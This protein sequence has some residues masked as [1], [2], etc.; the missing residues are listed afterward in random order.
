M[1]LGLSGPCGRV[2]FGSPTCRGPG[3]KTPGRG[4]GILVHLFGGLFWF[5]PRSRP[6]GRSESG[7]FPSVLGG[8]SFLLVTQPGKSVSSLTGPCLEESAIWSSA[9]SLCGLGGVILPAFGGRGSGV[10]GASSAPG[11][12]WAS[13]AG[14][15]GALPQAPSRTAPGGGAV[16]REAGTWRELS[17]VAPCGFSILPW[18]TNLAWSFKILEVDVVFFSKA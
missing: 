13:G 7:L 15:P 11:P 12:V 16:A 9:S 8:S 17:P 3:S 14:L 1:G 10:L 2:K 6:P 5:H 18:D 4:H